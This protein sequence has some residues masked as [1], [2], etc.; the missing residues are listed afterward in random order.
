MIVVLNL[1]IVVVGI[2]TAYLNR[3]DEFI[4]AVAV[5]A[6]TLSATILATRLSILEKGFI[7]P[8]NLGG[9]N[10]PPGAD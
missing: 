8:H 1:I 3:H 2:G 7:W 10:L 4:V 5:G 6:A 9:N